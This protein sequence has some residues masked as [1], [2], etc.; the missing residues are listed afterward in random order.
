M[1][2]TPSSPSAAP[3]AA[4]GESAE[5]G[6]DKLAALYRMSTTSAPASTEYT[7][8]NSVAVVAMLMGVAS[9]LALFSSMLLILP[10]GA[11]LLGFIALMQ[12]RRSA[13]TQTGRALAIG[14]M[15]IALGLGAL[16]GIRTVQAAQLAAA[17]RREVMDAI[18]QLGKKVLAAD[19]PAAYASCSP[20]F[21]GEFTAEQFAGGWQSLRS[22]PGSGDMTGFEPNGQV[23]FEASGPGGLPTASAGINIRFAKQAEPTTPY[24]QFVQL[25]GQWLVDAMSLFKSQQNRRGVS[26]TPAAPGVD[27]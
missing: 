8:I 1:A 4:P 21:Q 11:L 7:A 5:L 17:N 18:T 6:T 13:G 23:F 3:P 25:N 20:R 10:A 26:R 15:V 24:V 9:V 12:I 19:Y 2:D 16:V 14:G 22:Y 27:R